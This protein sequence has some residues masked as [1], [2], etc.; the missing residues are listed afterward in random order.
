MGISLY[1]PAPSWIV[2]F[3][4]KRGEHHYLHLVCVFALQAEHTFLQYCCCCFFTSEC[5]PSRLLHPSVIFVS[6]S[7]PGTPWHWQNAKTF[8]WASMSC[9]GGRWWGKPGFGFP[10][11][12]RMRWLGPKL[13]QDCHEEWIKTQAWAGKLI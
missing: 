6:A 12:K 10:I 5:F 4:L 11:A 3:F 7:L 9:Y 1:A 8:N 13:S 2:L